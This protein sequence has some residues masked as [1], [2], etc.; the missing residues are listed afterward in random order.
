M[1]TTPPAKSR[2]PVLRL[3]HP[4]L[5]ARRPPAFVQS[6][7]G[8]FVVLCLVG[9]GLSAM[10]FAA[11]VRKSRPPATPAVQGA[12]TAPAAPRTPP[13]TFVPRDVLH[14]LRTVDDHAP[15]PSDAGLAAL[16]AHVR[17]LRKA[18]EPPAPRPDFVDFDPAESIAHPDVFRG[19]Y[20]RA[21]GRVTSLETR[22]LD[23]ASDP[24]TESWIYHGILAE[25]RTHFATGLLFQ[26]LDRPP[27]IGIAADLVEV[28][29]IFLQNVTFHPR[30]GPERPLPFLVLTSFRV[31]PREVTE[32]SWLDAL[33][34]PVAGALVVGIGL[35]TYIVIRRLE[36]RRRTG[37]LAIRPPRK[38]S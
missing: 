1:M 2:P 22:V 10:V 4:L 25:E 33:F 34:Y 3:R 11:S 7:E 23:G 12:E 8:R 18:T 28:E 27:E 32:K 37:G 31:V 24:G 20:V 36:K 26:T 38:E 13:R 16:V 29:G 15:D 5:G 35:T 21:R 9:L 14:A 17:G 6:R 30:R 19:G